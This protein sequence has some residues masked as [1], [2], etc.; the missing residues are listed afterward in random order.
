M[1]SYIQFCENNIVTCYPNNK[2]W[3][4][5]ELKQK[6]IT[7]RQYIY[8]KDRLQLKTLQKELDKEIHQCK[9]NY[10]RK[11]EANFSEGHSKQTWKGLQ[12]ITGY[13]TEP[14]SF[15]NIYS[16][17]AKELCDNLNTFYSRFDSKENYSTIIDELKT[18]CDNDNS[19]VLIEVNTKCFYCSRN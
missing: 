5:K 19:I 17:D 16:A 13:N 14:R 4:T 15:S 6:L 3:L 10:K 1:S 12:A 2:H 18:V 11:L 8:H 7:K 9:Q